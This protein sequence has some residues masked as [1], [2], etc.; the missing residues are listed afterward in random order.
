MKPD[1]KWWQAL[2]AKSKNKTETAIVEWKEVHRRHS[3]DRKVRFEC[4]CGKK[5]LVDVWI[6]SNQ[7]NGNEVVLGSCCINRSESKSPDGD[8]ESIICPTRCYVPGTR[9][10]SNSLRV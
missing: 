3:Y 9:E 2:I 7:L 8:G 1:E 5:G 10:R 4:I 6:F